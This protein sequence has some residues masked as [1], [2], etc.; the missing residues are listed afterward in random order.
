MKYVLDVNI[1]EVSY[2][3][4]FLTNFLLLRTIIKLI[5]NANIPERQVVGSAVRRDVL[6]EF[7]VQ[8]AGRL[9]R[10]QKR[11]LPCHLKKDFQQYW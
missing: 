5:L 1:K 9:P 6:P 11:Y 2:H 8:L 3:C 7:L 4:N 10:E